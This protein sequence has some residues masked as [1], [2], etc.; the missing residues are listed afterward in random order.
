MRG[1]N[2]FEISK[3]SSVPNAGDVHNPLWDRRHRPSSPR[4]NWEKE[5]CTKTGFGKSQQVVSTTT[6]IDAD[7]FR[8]QETGLQNLVPGSPP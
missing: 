3:T 2:R 5:S 1:L 4:W 8:F 6:S 7:T